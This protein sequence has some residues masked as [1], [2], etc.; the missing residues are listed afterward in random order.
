[1]AALLAHARAKLEAAR[2]LLAAR[3]PGDAASRA[4]YGAFHAV[5]AALVAR[6]HAYSSHAQVLGAFNRDFVHAG[7]FPRE[8]TAILA[9]LFE[10]RQTGDYPAKRADRAAPWSPR[11]VAPLRHLVCPAAAPPGLVL[12]TQHLP[13]QH[14]ALPVRRTGPRRATRNL[15]RLPRRGEGAGDARRALTS[16]S[17]FIRPWPVG[18]ASTS[19]ARTRD[20]PGSPHGQEGS[21]ICLPWAGGSGCLATLRVSTASEPGVALP[22]M[23]CAS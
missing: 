18:Q 6:G 3:A 16:P 23:A 8:F 1:V 11:A 12:L 21:H 14:A 22:R 19:T 15:G 20:R 4:Y 2:V 17:S 5:S 10:D 7:T 9:R 13:A